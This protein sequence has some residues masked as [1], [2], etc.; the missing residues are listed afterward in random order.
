M[1]LSDAQIDFLHRVMESGNSHVSSPLEILT[2]QSVDQH[3]VR[4]KV[5]S[6]ADVLRSMNLGPGPLTTV[7][8]S[9][10]GEV[11]GD[12]VLL[13]TER[14]FQILSQVMGP[15][16]HDTALHTVG[17]ATDYMIPD[18]IKGR[19]I[20]EPDREA[21]Q[22]QM[23]DT[24]T[25]M[26]SV[27]FGAYLTALYSDYKLATYQDLPD[28]AVMDHRHSLLEKAPSRNSEETNIAFLIGID[29]V[30]AQ[31]SFKVWLLM[32]PLMSGLRA[33]LD[34]MDTTSPGIL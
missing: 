29:C 7:V 32:L 2:G 6:G 5:I 1:N 20:N 17:G 13:L 26:G 11:E 25:E 15:A 27:L 28:T 18:F 33:L 24:V 3:S 21:S 10:H 34:S 12:F 19:Q 16:L 22:A 8:S 9:V 31:K 14:D 30:I 4:I 23:L